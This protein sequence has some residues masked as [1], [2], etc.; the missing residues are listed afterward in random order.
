MLPVDDVLSW[1][2]MWRYMF[3]VILIVWLLFASVC[4]FY[5]YCWLI[6]FLN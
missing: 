1:T 4:M 6:M 2:L 5:F 3:C